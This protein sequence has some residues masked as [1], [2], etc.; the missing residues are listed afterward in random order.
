VAKFRPD[1]TYKSQSNTERKRQR[2]ER[3][4]Q[5]TFNRLAEEGLLHKFVVAV[6]RT[7]RLLG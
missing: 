4:E 5:H 3:E 6:R 1:P 2:M 7:N